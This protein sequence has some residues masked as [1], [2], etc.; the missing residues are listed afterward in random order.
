MI[1][2][3]QLAVRATKPLAQISKLE[4]IHN[5]AYGTCVSHHTLTDP[6][7]RGYN[8]LYA[9]GPMVTTEILRIFPDGSF[10]TKNT[11][12]EVIDTTPVTIPAEL[13]SKF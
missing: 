1:T 13:E 7:Y 8:G 2:S 5:R 3:E 9:G 10:E 11:Y 6:A 12:Y 4:L